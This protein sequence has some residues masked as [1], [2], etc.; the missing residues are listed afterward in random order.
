VYKKKIGNFLEGKTNIFTFPTISHEILEE[1]IC[2]LYYEWFIQ[3]HEK[4][5]QESYNGKEEYS[6]HSK[7][8]SIQN[9]CFP[10]SIQ[11]FKFIPKYDCV[12]LLIEAALYF[13]LPKLVDICADFIAKI[14]DGKN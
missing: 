7:F 13:D 2:Y 1:I 14:F 4:D 6:A 11:N 5:R 9:L 10:K 12:F 8:S 3:N